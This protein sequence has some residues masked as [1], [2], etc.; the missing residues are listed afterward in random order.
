MPGRTRVWCAVIAVFVVSAAIIAC[1]QMRAEDRHADQAADFAFQ[2]A[3]VPAPP[4]WSGPVFRRLRK[5]SGK[6]ST[7]DMGCRF[8]APA[9]P[10]VS[11]PTGVSQSLSVRLDKAQDPRIERDRN[12]VS[13]LGFSKWAVFLRKVGGLSACYLAAA[14]GP[15]SSDS[16]PSTWVSRAAST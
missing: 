14:L 3:A 12:I 9:L 1:S 16:Q 7:R 11:G 8:A 5:S 2:N 15:R 6:V 4:G 10:A 13:Q